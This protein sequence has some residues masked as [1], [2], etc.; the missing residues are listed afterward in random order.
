MDN[1]MLVRH[2]FFVLPLSFLLMWLSAQIGTLFRNRRPDLGEDVHQDNAVIVSATLT[3]LA[4]IIGF[5]F[6]MAIGRYDQRKDYEEAEANAIGTEYVRADLLPADDA[7]RVRSLLKEYVDARI[8]FY[9]TGDEHE[10]QRVITHTEKLQ[11]D[12]WSA[13]KTPA[14]A[15][16]S[17]V[18][19]L[20]LTGMNDVI[21]SQG[22]T[23]AG[24]WNRIP[25]GAWILM[26]VLA[27]WANLL[28]AYAARRTQGTFRLMFLPLILCVAFFLIADIDSPR[29]GVIRVLPQNLVSLAHSLQGH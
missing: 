23:Q 21:N 14:N 20:A 19:A 13:V 3:L 26:I 18:L 16:P 11:S 25:V 2:P 12:L 5:T 24:W 27:I 17:P 10:L 28:V 29:K 8:H 9:E 4:L 22:Y 1:I 15:R 6:S 7:A